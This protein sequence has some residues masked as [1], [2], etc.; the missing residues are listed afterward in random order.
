MKQLPQPLTFEPNGAFDNA[1]SCELQKIENGMDYPRIDQIFYLKHLNSLIKDLNSPIHSI[2]NLERQNHAEFPKNLGD[3]WS[4][5]L[6][7]V[8]RSTFSLW[9]E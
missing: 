3:F 7:A 1:M 6:D 4:M 8:K 2:P 9:I 5:P